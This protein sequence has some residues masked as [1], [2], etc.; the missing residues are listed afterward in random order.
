[1]R[2]VLVKIGKDFISNKWGI[3][4]TNT[5]HRF[6]FECEDGFV[7]TIPF[8]GKILSEKEIKE[9]IEFLQQ[10]LEEKEDHEQSDME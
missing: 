8:P 5:T 6:S 2:E 7:S 3:V 9:M 4:F 1:M 10:T